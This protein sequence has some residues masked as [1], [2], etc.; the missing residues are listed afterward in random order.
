LT[1]TGNRSLHGTILLVKVILQP[2][3][4]PFG[5]IAEGRLITGQ[6]GKPG[7]QKP[8]FQIFAQE[9]TLPGSQQHRFGT[10]KT[11]DADQTLDLLPDLVGGLL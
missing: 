7:V 1:Q 3:T 8:Q 2:L 6:Q 9:K 4:R 5:V 11:L 10:I